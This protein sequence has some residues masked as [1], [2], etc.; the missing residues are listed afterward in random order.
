MMRNTPRATT[1]GTQ[2]FPDHKKIVSRKSQEIE[3]TVTKKLSQEFRKTDSHVLDPLS[4]L[5]EFLLK[6]IIQGHSGSVLETSRNTYGRSQ[7]AN[8]EHSQ[9]DPNP[10]ARESQSQSTQDSG[11]DNVY[12]NRTHA[13][14]GLPGAPI[15]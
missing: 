12:D 1:H 3:S 15:D 5:D 11:P 8:E 14:N 2:M 4:R 13:T 6:P 7:G 10:E 9:T